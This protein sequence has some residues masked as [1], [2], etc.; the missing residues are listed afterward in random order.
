MNLMKPEE[1]SKKLGINKSA[2]PSLRKREQSFP[3]PIHVSKRI[4]RWDENEI[5]EWLKA[6]KES[7]DNGQDH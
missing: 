4:L 7:E 3:K 5:N 6:R 1:V 2:L